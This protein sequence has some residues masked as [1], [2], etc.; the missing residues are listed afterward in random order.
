MVNDLILAKAT[1]L[2]GGEKL[3][4]AGELVGDV[5]FLSPEQLGS[6]HP[7][8]CRSDIYQLGVTLY[9]L[10]TGRAPFS[11]ATVADTIKRI[12]TNAP[13]STQ[14]FHMAIPLQFNAVILKMLEKNP[15]D[16]FQHADD[17]AVALHKVAAETDQHIVKSREADPK[18]TGWSGAVEGLL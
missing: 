6:G 17:L 16:R 8:D 14:R 12:L 10:L 2:A 11:G 13:A 15:R 18:T 3:T 5:S 1:T 9:A 4:Q 7:V